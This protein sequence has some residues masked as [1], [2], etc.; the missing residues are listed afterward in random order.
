M[1][2]SLDRTASNSRAQLLEG[3]RN[4]DSEMQLLDVAAA[5]GIPGA[6]NVRYH[7]KPWNARGK[8]GTCD[9]DTEWHPKRATSRATD[10]VNI[11]FG[12]GTFIGCYIRSPGRN[13]FQ[14]CQTESPVLSHSAVQRVRRRSLLRRLVT[15]RLSLDGIRRAGNEVPWEWRSRGR[16]TNSLRATP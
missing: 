4:V 9:A 2:Y 8:R 10:T 6:G 7:T 14:A 16:S 1:F 3:K 5:K 11:A 15:Q 12:A 13:I